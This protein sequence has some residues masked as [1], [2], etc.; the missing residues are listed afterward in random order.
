MFSPLRFVPRT[1]EHDYADI[2]PGG[3]GCYAQLP[4]VTGRGRLEIGLQKNGCIYERVEAIH[5]VILSLP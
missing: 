5:A 1:N 4:Y 3:G 2:V